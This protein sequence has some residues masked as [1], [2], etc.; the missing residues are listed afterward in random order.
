MIDYFRTVAPARGFAIHDAI[1]N[2]NGLGL[3][4]RMVSVAAVPSQAEV[5]RLQPG[6]TLDL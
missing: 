6:A 2:E 3:M 5:A 4:T 1:L